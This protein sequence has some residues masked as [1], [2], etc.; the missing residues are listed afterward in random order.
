MVLVIGAAVPWPLAIAVSR[1]YERGKIGVGGDEMHA[2]GRTLILAIAVERHAGPL[3]ASAVVAVFAG[4]AVPVA[5]AAWI[6]IASS[7]ARTS[8]DASVPG[9]TSAG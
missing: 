6:G 3:P 4:I 9:R 5:A 1:G 2:V 8:T 7:G